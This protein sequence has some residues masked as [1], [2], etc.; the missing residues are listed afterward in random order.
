MLR[1]WDLKIVLER[2]PVPAWSQIADALI[3]AIRRGRLAPGTALPG[4]RVL[5]ERLNVNRKTVGQAYEELVSQGWLTAEATRGTFVSAML[6]IVE[7]HTI[8]AMAP[9]GP[10]FEL[11]GK[12]PDL[13]VS[14]TGSDILRFDD[15]TPDTRLMPAELLARA[16]RRALLAR[17]RRNELGYGDPRGTSALREAVAAMLRADRG[18]NCTAENICITRGSQM[19]I[20][21]AAKLLAGPGDQV[22]IE[23]LSYPP[24]RAAFVATGARIVRIGVDGQGMRVED[25]EALCREGSLRAIYITPHHQFPTTVVLPQQRR[26][27]LLALADQFGFA[28]VE[29]DYDHEFHFGH[30]PMLP[31]AS[32]HGF[33][34][35]IYIGSLSKLFSPSLR[36]GYLVA[37]EDVVARAAAEIMLIDRQGDP[38][39]QAAAAELMVTGA[40]KSHTRKVLR[41]YAQRRELLA[42]LLSERLSADAEF[43]LPLGGLAVWV[44]FAQQIDVAALAAAALRL[45]LEITPGQRFAT[46]GMVTNG[47][48]LGFAGL[49][50][51]EMKRAVETLADAVRTSP[52]RDGP[53]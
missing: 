10:A 13:A 51:Q 23:A 36:I 50:D 42:S 52:R 18:L 4:T 11:R 34:R 5:A 1:P 47:A 15:G 49:D 40:L 7:Q 35:L 26:L 17:A 33:E 38:V 44:N 16:Y 14:L 3:E 12:A 32:A 9:R 6:P 45:G 27:Q 25:L 41:I 8:T 20:Y 48:R 43:T 28:I 30:R 24:A 31:L 22:G 29:D 2:G 19:A 37:A 39:G 46:N 53:R 21:L